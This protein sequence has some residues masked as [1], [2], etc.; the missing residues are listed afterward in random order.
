MNWS[1]VNFFDN[2]FSEDV[3]DILFGLHPK[4]DGVDMSSP[5]N[6]SDGVLM[7]FWK[8][9]D[10]RRCLLKGG[11]GAVRQEPFNE[12]IASTVMEALG[13]PHA[14][15]GVIWVSDRPC[16][17]CEDFVTTETELVSASAVMSSSKKRNDATLYAHWVGCCSDLGVDIVPHMDR[18]LAVDYLMGNTDRHTGNFGLLRDPDTLGWIGPAPVFD[19]GTSLGCDLPTRD[20]ASRAGLRSKPFRDAWDEQVLLISDLSWLDF[21]ALDSAL[22]GAGDILDSS[23]GGVDPA[24]RDALVGFLRSRADA[25]ERMAGRLG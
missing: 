19:T 24:R 23:R 12:A 11:T 16:S 25:L 22:S 3:G 7:I 4:A 5:D 1:D 13:I 9:V 2:P 14:E 21:D 10:G 17:I 8:I 18:M 15:Y 6:T 20:I